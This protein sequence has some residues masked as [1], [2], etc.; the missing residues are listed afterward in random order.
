MSLE[1]DMPLEE[2]GFDLLGPFPPTKEVTLTSTSGMTTSWDGKA[3]GPAGPRT[4]ARWRPSS[5]WICLQ[6]TYAHA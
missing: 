6:A 5:R 1:V 4:R 3:Q 2:V